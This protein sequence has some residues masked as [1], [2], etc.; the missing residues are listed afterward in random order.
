[1]SKYIIQVQEITELN[2]CLVNETFAYLLVGQPDASEANRNYKLNFFFSR[3][4][5]TY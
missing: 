3:L 5:Y 2:R 4:V 1:M